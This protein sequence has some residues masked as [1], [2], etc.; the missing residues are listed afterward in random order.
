MHRREAPKH[1][2]CAVL[3]VSTSKAKKAEEKKREGKNARPADIGDLSGEIALKLLSE[4][5]HEVV[6]Y[7]VLPDERE[8]IREA[9]ERALS[10]DAEVVVTTGGTGLASSDVTIEVVAE[11]LEKHIPGFG[12]IFRLKSYEKVGTAAILSRAI[13]GVVAGKVIFC[14]PGSPSAVEL[15]LKEIILKEL[16]H[17]MK[18]VRE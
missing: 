3:T 17:I 6:L 9:V 8:R 11:M 10:S 14:L 18:H 1:F 5:G 13:A 2:K 7:D 4:S 16:P 15:A 12:E